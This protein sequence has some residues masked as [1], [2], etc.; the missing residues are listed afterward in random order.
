MKTYLLILLT[1]LLAIPLTAQSKKKSLAITPIEP[2]PA[3]AASLNGDADKAA[4]LQSLCQGLEHALTNTL[5]ASR[6]VSLVE[7]SE[8]MQELI[9]EI[10]LSEAG[11]IAKKA[12]ELGQ[13]TGA[14]TLLLPTLTTFTLT[15][16]T[17]TINGVKQVRLSCTIAV[18]TRLVAVESGEILSTSNFSAS[19]YTLTD[20]RFQ[21]L[22]LFARFQ[23]I[24]PIIT[25]EIAQQ[26]TQELIATLYPAKVIDVDG[27]TL[28]INRGKDTFAIGDLLT[29]TLPGRKVTD[30]DTGETYE[31]PGRV[32]G[33]ARVTYV[34]TTITQA[35]ANPGTTA[36]IG[37]R[38][39]K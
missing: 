36:K 25:N 34:D 23:E 9:K 17:G 1:L 16:A 20:T 32:C 35:E 5:T 39:S 26:S 14:E 10:N 38:V 8:K 22:D 31:I 4:C 2:T 33:S 13:M 28:T 27:T 19:H 7:R 18:Q 3:L 24:L 6:K 15:D 29:V 11:L 21:T 12:S 37:A 30:P